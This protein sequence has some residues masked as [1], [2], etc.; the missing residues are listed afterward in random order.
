MY[1]HPDSSAKSSYSFCKVKLILGHALHYFF[2]YNFKGI[3][4]KKMFSESNF[5]LD[6]HKK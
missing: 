3:N 1:M 2:Q 5:K 6:L 4:N